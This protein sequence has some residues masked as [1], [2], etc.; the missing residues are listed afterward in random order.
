MG[1]CSQFR[2]GQL[3]SPGAL[4]G[5]AGRLLK[6]EV[7]AVEEPVIEKTIPANVATVGGSVRYDHHMMAQVQQERGLD[8]PAVTYSTFVAANQ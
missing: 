1:L 5:I 8:I 7:D 3:T 4:P 6:Q 2:A